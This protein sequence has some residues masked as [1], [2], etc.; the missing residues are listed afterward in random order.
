MFDTLQTGSEHFLIHGPVSD[1]WDIRELANCALH[2][3]S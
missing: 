3:S 1:W 2:G